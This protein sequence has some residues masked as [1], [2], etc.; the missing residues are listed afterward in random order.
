LIKAVTFDLWNTLVEDKSYVDERVE[1]LA[2]ALSRVGVSKGRSELREAYHASY[3]YAH[4][5]WENEN[6]R[7]VTNEERL[8]YILER[9]STRL[10]EDLRLKVL[11]DFEEVALLDPPPLAEG[12]RETLKSLRGDYRMGVICDVGITPGRILRRVLEDYGIL[13]FFDTTVFSDENGYCKPHRKI[14][15][16]ALT[17]LDVKPPEAIHIGDLLQTDIAGAKAIGM[18]AVWLNKE[19]RPNTEPYRPNY[20]VRML[21]EILDILHGTV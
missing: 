13:K 20:E 12:V 21:P 4:K 6:H 11:K 1:C 9:L 16:K 17:D 8:N 10:T 14:F 15:E 19:G 5:V 18:R 2:D 3:N 7:H